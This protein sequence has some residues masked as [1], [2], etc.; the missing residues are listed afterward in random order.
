MIGYG[1]GSAIV[2]MN[3]LANQTVQFTGGSANATQNV[4][5]EVPFLRGGNVVTI[6][7]GGDKVWIDAIVVG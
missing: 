5:L 7:G 3:F 4:T 6:F 1:N 2:G